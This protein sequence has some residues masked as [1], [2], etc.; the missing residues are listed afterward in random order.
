MLSF[1]TIAPVTIH[2]GRL[3]LTPDQIL[4]RASMVKAD[5]GGIC[6]I[7]KPVQFKAGE[8]FDYDGEIPKGLAELVEPVSASASA[9]GDGATPK[10]IRAAELKE[11]TGKII[12]LVAKDFHIKTFG[13]KRVNVEAAIL[14]AEFPE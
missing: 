6:E 1:R 5:A 7:I 13:V 14:A 3:R 9:S 4:P 11:M 10:D 8:R 12:A 2:A